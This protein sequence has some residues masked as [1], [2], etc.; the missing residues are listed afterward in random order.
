MSAAHSAFAVCRSAVVWRQDRERDHQERRSP[1]S[2]GHQHRGERA[3]HRALGGQLD[4]GRD[5]VPRV[6]GVVPH[7]Q[8][9]AGRSGLRPRHVGVHAGVG[10]AGGERVDDAGPVAGGE[11]GADGDRELG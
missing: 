7:D 9:R 11:A 1:G 4:G 8:V 6:V 3:D 10:V 5:R 2:V